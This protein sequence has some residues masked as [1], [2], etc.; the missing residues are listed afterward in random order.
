MYITCMSCFTQMMGMNDEF[1]SEKKKSVVQTGSEMRCVTFD[2][3]MVS[4]TLRSGMPHCIP[5]R[6]AV[7]LWRVLRKTLWMTEFL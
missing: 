2:A 3:V 4:G 7:L 1:V 5:L 6:S